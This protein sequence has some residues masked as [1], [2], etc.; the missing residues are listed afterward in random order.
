M[1]KGKMQK[2][3]RL[4]ELAVEI[5]LLT[6][7]LTAVLTATTVATTVSIGDGFSDPGGTTVVPLMIYDVTGVSGMSLNL[8][9]D[10]SVVTVVNLTD[11]DFEIPP[12]DPPYDRGPGW[13]VIDAG[14]VVKPPL[15][16]NV[17]IC[18]VTLQAKGVAGETSP[19][20]LTEVELDDKDLNPLPVDSL[21]NGTFRINGPPKPRITSPADGEKISG[22]VTIEEVDDSGEGD[23]AYN[24]FEYYYDANCNGLADDAG[25]SWTEIGN[26]TNGADGWSVNWNTALL[27]DC[28]Y[29]IRATMADKHGRTGTDEIQVAL[30][31]HDPVTSITNPADGSIIGGVVTIVTGADTGFDAGADIAYT[32]FEHYYDANCNCVQDDG[33]TLVEIGNDTNGA[34]GWSAD[35]NTAGLTECY[36]IFAKMT[37]KHGRT[38]VSEINVEIDTT[39]PTVTDEQATP[40]VIPND[41]DDN[42][43]WGETTNLTATVTD[44]SGVASVRIDLSQIG[45]SATQAMTNIGGNLWSVETNASAGTAPANYVLVMTV[46]DTYGNSRTNNI[47]LR[48]QKNGDVQPYDG[49]GVVDFM[50]DAIYLVR[51][52]R[53]VPGYENIRDNIADVTGDGVVDFMGDAIYLVRHTRNV[54][55]YEILK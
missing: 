55:G 35:W 50:G 23:I 2:G 12:Q 5:S 25:S 14:Q 1:Q 13:V 15:N 22:T 3:R 47:N 31:N 37:D 48:V 28:C 27:N 46:T 26:D 24:L 30:S 19:L 11:S 49:N 42:P 39:P 32:R 21:R 53:N 40:N 34:D 41:T 18:D 44:V 52:T 7:V 9:F 20:L 17:K 45:G 29:L 10:E 8:T 4:V 6:V 43:L 51:H 16:G 33:S 38:G 36:M 54:G